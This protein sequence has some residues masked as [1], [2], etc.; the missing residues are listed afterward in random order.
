MRTCSRPDCVRK[1]LAGGFC[2]NHY[3]KDRRDR[4]IDDRKNRRVDSPPQVAVLTAMASLHGAY[5]PTPKAVKA[6]VTIGLMVDCPWCPDIMA[7]LNPHD[8]VCR[9]CGTTLTLNAE[10]V[11]WLT[12]E[13][14]SLR[15]SLQTV[16]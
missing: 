13:R 10:E 8:R 11:E 12:S 7:A 9:T 3:Y 6:R 2:R 5:F 4:G 1:H 16:S 14:R 15:A